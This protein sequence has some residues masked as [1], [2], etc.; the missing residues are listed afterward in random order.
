VPRRLIFYAKR[1]ATATKCCN[2]P[3]RNFNEC[4]FITM[5]TTV[6]LNKYEMDVLFEQRPSTENDGGW[7]KLMIKLQRACDRTTGVIQIEAD[8]LARISKYAFDM[9]HGGWED[10]LIK[11]F[12]RTLGSSLGR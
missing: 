1:E 8:T 5:M 2:F 11:V 3:L 4:A 10:R 6:T 7:Q 9:G 12:G